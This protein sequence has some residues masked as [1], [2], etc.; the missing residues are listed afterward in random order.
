MLQGGGQR[1]VPGGQR[2]DALRDFVHDEVNCQR[3]GDE[4]L[5]Y[6]RMLFGRTAAVTHPSFVECMGFGLSD[7][8]ERCSRLSA[9]VQRDPQLLERSLLFLSI[10]GEVIW[11]RYGGESEPGDRVFPQPQLLIDI[12]KELVRHDLRAQLQQLAS[13]PSAPGG[14]L[15]GLGEQFCDTGVLDRRLLPWLWRD[16][17]FPLAERPEEIAFVLQL[18]TQLG[19]LTQLPH[20]TNQWLLPLRL[21]AKDIESMLSSTKAGAAFHTFLQR[22][23]QSGS[24]VL[25]GLQSVPV[26]SLEQSLSYIDEERI[27]AAVLR[28]ARDA[29]LE[30]ADQLLETGLDRHSLSRDDIAAIHLYT[31]ENPIY[32][33]LNAALRTEQREEIKPFWSYIKL[34]QTALF[35]LPKDESGAERGIESRKLLAE[36][37]AAQALH[38]SG[39]PLLWWGFSSSST[40][41]PAVKSF[42]GESARA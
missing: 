26:V 36:Y 22:L 31:Q 20:H 9:K 6:Y 2:G 34:L 40:S 7:L 25:A 19:L 33:E 13:P 29:A 21:P 35:K 24:G 4:L 3:R 10:T 39:D 11:P 30:R 18:L 1:S 16:L 38:D 32:G 15:C 27:P 5:G 42:L 12:M 28:A 41:M 17:S 14:E 23:E 37:R 8:Q